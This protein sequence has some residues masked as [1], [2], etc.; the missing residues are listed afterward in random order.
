MIDNEKTY[1]LSRQGVKTSYR[2]PQPVVRLL[3]QFLKLP[4]KTGV[5]KNIKCRE[6]KKF[7]DN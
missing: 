3:E 4:Y 1:L 2:E 5:G 7:S 6:T